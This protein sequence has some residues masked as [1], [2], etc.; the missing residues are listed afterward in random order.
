M[1]ESNAILHYLAEA[2]GGFELWS[3]DVKER[4]DIT[5][6]LFWESSQWQPALSEVLAP[7]VAQKLGLVAAMPL[8][9]VDWSHAGFRRVT[10]F[11]EITFD[12]RFLC[13]A[14]LTLA[15][16]SVAAMLTY[17]RAARFPFDGLP[18]IGRWYR[19]IEQLDAWQVTAVE[20]WT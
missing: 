10:R 14:R 4:A 16:F 5:R 12:P 15:D 19:T 2:Y 9:S 7:V 17:A 20:P 1:S 3:R 6:W 11:L 18:N 8:A 13:L